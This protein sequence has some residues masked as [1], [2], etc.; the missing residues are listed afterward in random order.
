M[1]YNAD[2]SYLFVNGKE[3]YK[4]KAD[5]KDENF[6]TQFCLQ[7]V[8]VK[9]DESK[10][11]SLTGDIYDFSDDCDTNYHDKFDTLNIHKYLMVKNNVKCLNLLKNSLLDY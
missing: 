6:P 5:N 2:N 1:H 3:I 7:S 10:E 4:F 8:S 9:F 11:V